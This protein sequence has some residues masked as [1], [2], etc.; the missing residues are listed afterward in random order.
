MVIKLRDY[1]EDISKKANHILT[2]KGMV[3]LC[4]SVRTGKT[5]TSLETA[6]LFGAKRV[7]FL[8]K[9]KAISSIESDYINFGYDKHF[10]LFVHND[11]SMHKIDGKFDL[12]VHDE[13]HRFGSFPKPSLGAKTFKKMFGHLPAIFLSGTPS[14]ENYSQFYHQFWCSL[15]SPFK[16]INF[17]KWAANYV[18]IKMK[19]LGYAQ[20]KDYTDADINKIM[21]V[22][23]P[24]II[25][26]TQEQAGFT[27]E[28][29]EEVLK[30]KM[31]NSTYE[32]CERLRKDLVIE[33]K[34][35]VILADTSVKLQ[36]KLHQMYSGTIKFESGDSMV[37]DL[38]KAEFIYSY[39]KD[40]KI[41]IFYKFV[42]ELNALKTIFGDK[43]T[44]NLDEFND[45]DKSIALQ[46]VSGREGI[47]L[48][49]AEFLVFY[50][51]DFSA[52][53]YFQAKDRMTTIDRKFNKVY[54][55]FSDGG[56]EEK[57]YKSVIKKKS[58][59]TNHFK[60]D[61]L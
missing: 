34:N 11:E 47:S 52:T 22:I 40:K 18:N 55:I 10:E 9:K 13:H 60:K 44:I 8:T 49:N 33:G 41:G 28:I 36:Q 7:L 61:Y 48:K 43:L 25:T 39:F 37:I 53:S 51:I 35:Q 21:S 50:N 31:K 46:I 3:Y 4:M 2:S 56:I 1:Q 45:S 17:Y 6:R 30:V 5:L 59:T 29:E 27:S 23:K 20:V 24:Y 57:I 42:E 58:Y 15:F 16:E 19:H 32:M 14:P 54:W 12:V 38:S 26:F